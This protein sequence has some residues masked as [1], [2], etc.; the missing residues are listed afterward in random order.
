MQTIDP[1]VGNACL[2]A[3]RRHTMGEPGMTEIDM[4]VN[5]ADKI[6]LTRAPYPHLNEVREAA[7]H[8]LPGAL[9]LSL[10]GTE[11]YVADRGEKLHP[12]TADTL[13]WLKA[14]AH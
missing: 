2:D 4:A 6:E 14:A 13:A 11:S 8:S 12:M 9:R 5:L 7:Q 3:I 10:E 1:I